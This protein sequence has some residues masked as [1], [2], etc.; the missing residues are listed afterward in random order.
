MELEGGKRRGPWRKIGD[1]LKM[2]RF[3]LETI[4]ERQFELTIFQIDFQYSKKPYLEELM[5]PLEN[6]YYSNT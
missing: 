5:V 4:Y 3:H 1:I 6:L 2:G